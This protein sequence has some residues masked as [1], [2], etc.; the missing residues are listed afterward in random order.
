M[1][2]TGTSVPPVMRIVSQAESVE[3]RVAHLLVLPGLLPHAESKLLSFLQYVRSCDFSLR[4]GGIMVTRGNV[5]KGLS[6]FI[7]VYLLVIR[8]IMS[9]GVG[10]GSFIV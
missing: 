2:L 4:V 7:T 1:L 6:L 5:N 10:S 9:G 8:N 3:R